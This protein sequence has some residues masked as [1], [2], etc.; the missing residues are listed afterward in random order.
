[1]ATLIVYDE[2]SGEVVHTHVEADETR[3]S[4][5][6]LLRFVDPDLRKKGLRVTAVDPALVAAGYGLRVHAKS[7]RVER[8]DVAD[9]RGAGGGGCGVT[10]GRAYGPVEY[11]D[12][13][14]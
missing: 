1:M 7:G 2:D 9:C 11:R 13:K 4:D 8:V 12:A 6:D 5:E 10:E 14:A 3:M